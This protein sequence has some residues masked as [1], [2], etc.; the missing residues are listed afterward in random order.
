MTTP[1][2]VLTDLGTE[3]GVLLGPDGSTEVDVFKGSVQAQVVPS[4]A[5]RHEPRILTE[6]QAATISTGGIALVPSGAGPQQF[7]RSLGT[8]AAVLDMVDLLCG[9]DGTTHRR[10]RGIDV[11]DGS[12]GT[13]PQSGGYVGDGQY[14]RVPSLPVIDGCFVPNGSGK[15]PID[16]SGHG[17]LFR[18]NNQSVNLIWAGGAIPPPPLGDAMMTKLGGVDYGQ[19]NH[20]LIAMHSNKGFTLSL[21][22]VRHLYPRQR[23]A[24][25]HCIAGDSY[26]PPFE[27]PGR[28]HVDLRVLIDGA[29]V[30]EKRGFADGQPPFSVDIP[31]KD[32]DRFL[33]FA[34]TDGGDGIANDYVLLG[35][36][37]IDLSSR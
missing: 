32:E 29:P 12:A 4:E 36:P 10:G 9:G 20:G 17:F 21:D 3:F 1:R 22:A 33:T 30:F 37:G 7:V 8:E 24:R 27:P 14:H 6:G 13:L 15:L 5:G 34:A 11:R 23:P 26:V 31:L 19:P 35:D 16:S 28:R 18:A 2:A 25:F